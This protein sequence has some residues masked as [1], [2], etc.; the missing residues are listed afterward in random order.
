[1][2]VP[3]LYLSR[4][5][6]TPRRRDVQ[7]DLANC[8]AL[9]QRLLSAFPDAEDIEQARAH[10]G[11]LYRVEQPPA[12]GPSGLVVLV[13]SREV[14]DWSRLPTDYLTHT[15]VKQIASSYDAL[16]AGRALV[17]RLRANPR[18]RISDRDSTQAERWRGKRGK[19]RRVEEELQWR[20]RTGKT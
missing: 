1:M 2:A 9:H 20:Q 6:L 14:P 3:P 15:A 7:R 11:V 18:R 16:R 10:F 12:A 13:Q 5:P 4:R 8:Y 19:L 17:F